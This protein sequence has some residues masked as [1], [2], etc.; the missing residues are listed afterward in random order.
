MTKKTVLY[1]DDEFILRELI[2]EILQDEGFDVVTLSSF[3]ELQDRVN[4]RGLGEF[5]VVI[6]DFSLR[7]FDAKPTSE[8]SKNGI[9]VLNL[10]R[11]TRPE[12][13]V[14]LFSADA[15]S[16]S[17]NQINAF[18]YVLKSKE[19]VSNIRLEIPTVLRELPGDKCEP[20]CQ[21]PKPS[22]GSDLDT[23]TS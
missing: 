9:D 5:D 22:D 19:K 21:R 4:A 13:P 20:T 18:S 14:L 2:S 7:S 11:E 12:L 8:N 1:I 3:S 23:L 15:S 17:R 6:T 16:L 10:V